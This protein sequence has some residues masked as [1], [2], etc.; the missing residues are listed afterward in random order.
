MFENHI[1]FAVQNMNLFE[2]IYKKDSF[3][4]DGETYP[5]GYTSY[6]AIQDECRF[7]ESDSVNALLDL[8]DELFNDFTIEKLNYYHKFI[9][10]TIQSLKDNPFFAL[11]DFDK[12]ADRI[13]RLFSDKCKEQYMDIY[14]V[15][16]DNYRV[17]TAEQ[18]DKL[19]ELIKVF[20][21]FMAAL[22]I[23]IILDNAVEQLKRYSALVFQMTHRI[24][25]RGARNRSQLA[26]AF[27]DFLSD[28]YMQFLFH[29]DNQPFRTKASVMPVIE[30]V[31]GENYIFRKVYYNN[32]KDFLYT[33]LFEG[34]IHGHYLWRCDI[35]DDYFFMT[36]AHRQL[37]CSKVNPKYGV[38]CSYVAKHPEVTKRK[39]ERQKKTDSPY[40][41][42]WKKRNDLIRKNKS[43]GKYNE[44]VSAKAKEYIDDCFEEARLDF[45][46]AETQ[47]EKD[48]ETEMIYKV[49]ME[50]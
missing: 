48:M 20:D 4:L 43:L 47:Y 10:L 41:L 3:V 13:N 35:C 34:Y 23:P 7:M 2:I 39:M 18:A 49:A 9:L 30:K 21:D 45:E 37:Y 5:I 12:V 1:K 46:Y 38:P 27:G 17:E 29:T 22:A 15:Y 24:V 40:Y 14:I 26:D 42:L 16:R 28:E 25:E 36:T 19:D 11:F 50:M 33:D 8:H 44:E 6:L 32:L 31:N